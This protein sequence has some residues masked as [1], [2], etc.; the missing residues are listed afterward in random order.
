[1]L[2]IKVKFKE[3]ITRAARRAR[4][5]HAAFQSGRVDAIAGY[6]LREVKKATPRDPDSEKHAADHWG[7]KWGGAGADRSFALENPFDYV[8]YLE[9]GTPPHLIFPRESDGKL[10]FDYRG[11]HF[12]LS[13]VFVEGIKEMG[14][15]RK[16]QS[17][18]DHYARGEARKYERG[19]QR[20]WF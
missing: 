12:I 7:I 13:S 6:A 1:M 17:K 15:V 19:V 5:Y 16:T 11:E 2:N 10:A 3:T 8:D 9:Y 4:A 20:A 18:V 14:F